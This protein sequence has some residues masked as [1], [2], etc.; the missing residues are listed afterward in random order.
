[1]VQLP[2]GRFPDAKDSVNLSW[3]FNTN[4]EI[5]R[6]DVKY[7]PVGDT[8]YHAPLSVWDMFG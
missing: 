7:N 2:S 6:I 3:M 4:P 1:M 5:A 8:E